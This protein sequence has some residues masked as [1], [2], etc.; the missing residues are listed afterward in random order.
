MTRVIL[1]PLVLIASFLAVGSAPAV[2]A[3]KHH[4]LLT[5]S[6]CAASNQTTTFSAPTGYRSRLLPFGYSGQPVPTSDLT[7]AIVVPDDEVD[8][9]RE[10]GV[11]A[12]RGRLSSATFTIGVK[13]VGVSN[14]VVP[15]T[16]VPASGAMTLIAKGQLRAFT[17]RERKRYPVKVPA[18]LR[19]DLTAIT[20]NRTAAFQ[21]GCVRDSGAPV[22]LTTF[23]IR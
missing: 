9:L 2:A 17:L 13:K 14:M 1:L 6:T 23:R 21:V 19:F 4:T 10:L 12:V 5:Q 16:P 11:E 8:L 3:P 18:R 15:R 20:A 22:K 7:V